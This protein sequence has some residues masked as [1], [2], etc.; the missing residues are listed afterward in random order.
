MKIVCYGDSNTYGFDPRSY[1]GARYP[2]ED[3]WVDIMG[4][5]LGCKTVNAG[6]NGREIPRNRFELTAFRN[7]LVDESPVD[8]LVIMLGTNDLLQGNAAVDVVKRM[9][10]F[11]EQA[12]MDPG[13]ILLIAPPFL[14]P[15]EWVSS[16][17]LIR[18]SENLSEGYRNLAENL[19]VGF[20]DAGEWN[21]PIAFDGVHLTSEGHRCF[22]R[23]LVE[24][25]NKGE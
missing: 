25:L 5:Q 8:L 11:L 3:R 14:R 23:G 6:E 17:E 21:I 10:V 15:G 13:K 7:M 22:A 20:A 18:A 2:E 19:G 24:Y 16:T 12:E 9:E 1:F 4:K